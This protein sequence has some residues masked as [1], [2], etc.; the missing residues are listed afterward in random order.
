MASHAVD[1]VHRDLKPSN[2]MVADGHAFSDVK[3]TD[4][5]IAKMAEAE[6]GQW[7]EVGGGTSSKTVLGAIPY[8]SPEA[9]NDFKKATKPSDVW[10]IAAIVY[11]L[12]SGDLPFGTGLKSIPNIIAAV[13]PPL[14][15]QLKSAQFSS[16]GGELYSIICRCL[17][18][19]P[20]KRPDAVS[21]VSMCEELCYATSKY[22]LGTVLDNTGYTGRIIDKEGITLMYHPSNFYGSSKVVIGSPVWF[23]R[24]EGVPM[25]RAF[26]I[27]VA[28]PK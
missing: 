14:P 12:L 21:L 7:A 6:I 11:Q 2:I 16:L 18:K 4:F 22:S 27:V 20:A 23:G 19:D 13:P 17:D 1:V 25:D 3:I 24:A 28:L 10:A 8:M 9:I 5:G 26:P 15:K